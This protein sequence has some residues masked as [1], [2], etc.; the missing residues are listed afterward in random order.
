VGSG[1]A[2]DMGGTGRQDGTD[3][4]RELGRQRQTSAP[5]GAF[6]I[7]PSILV[8]SVRSVLSSQVLRR[9]RPTPGSPSVESSGAS[10]QPAGLSGRRKS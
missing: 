4:P 9:T 3:A 5:T 6:S 1:G 10:L 8:G 2:A 7:S